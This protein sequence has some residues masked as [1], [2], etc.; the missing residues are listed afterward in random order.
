MSV[1]GSVNHRAPVSTT[2]LVSP[3]LTQGTLQRSYGIAAGIIATGF[4]ILEIVLAL[5]TTANNYWC[6]GTELLGTTAANCTPRRTAA[7]R[8]QPRP[9]HVHTQPAT[10][11]RSLSPSLPQ[12]LLLIAWVLVSFSDGRALGNLT[13]VFAA[14][15]PAA[16]PGGS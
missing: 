12:V 7:L 9:P 13:G 6:A 2:L 10:V 5:T 14:S 3:R 4:F 8:H 11:V 1:A 16:L 15:R